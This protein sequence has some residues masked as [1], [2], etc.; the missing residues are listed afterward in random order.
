MWNATYHCASLGKFGECQL[1]TCVPLIRF[2]F[3]FILDLWKPGF[4]DRVGAFISEHTSCSGKIT[5]LQADLSAVLPGHWQPSPKETHQTFFS[6]WLQVVAV[7]LQLKEC[8]TVAVLILQAPART[9][10]AIL[11]PIQIVTDM[12]LCDY[13][14]ARSPTSN[15]FMHL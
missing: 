5:L 13:F 3:N 7:V 2:M 1:L 8:P 4:T 15:S 9:V 11:G 12:K 14:H 10:T 6:L